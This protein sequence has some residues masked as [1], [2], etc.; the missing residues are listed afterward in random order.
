MAPTSCLPSDAKALRLSETTTTTT[1]QRQF[2]DQ[3]SQLIVSD[4]QVIRVTA[5]S[6]SV[7]LLFF[8]RRKKVEINKE[9]GERD[10]KDEEPLL[11]CFSR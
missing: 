9:Q 3:R 7:T 2:D 5:I 4:L 8:L 10:E 11:C 1:K 6:N